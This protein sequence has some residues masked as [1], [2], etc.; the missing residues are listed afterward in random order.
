MQQI[1]FHFVHYIVRWTMALTIVCTV[2]FASGQADSARFK[3]IQQ[4]LDGC[5]K[6]QYSQFKYSKDDNFGAEYR[7]RVHSSAPIFSL[8]MKD[9]NIYIEWTELTGGENPQKI[10]ELKGRKLTVVNEV[11]RKIIYRRNKN[12]K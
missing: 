9:G 12:C 6:T 3:F 5:W 1:Q 8:M 11:G 4:Q 10:L 2:A 7:S